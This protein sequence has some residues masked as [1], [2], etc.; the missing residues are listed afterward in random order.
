MDILKFAE[1]IG[2]LKRLKRTGWV[3]SNIPNPESVAEHSFRV[4]ILTMVLAPILGVDEAKAVKMAL[5]HDLGE[6][7][8]GDIVTVRRGKRLANQKTKLAAERK[9]LIHILT[10]IDS[11]Q[12]Y[13]SLF[14]EYEENKTPEARLVKQI[15][16][17]EMGI[18]ALEYEQDHGIDLE[19]F[20][21]TTQAAVIHEELRLILEV[22]LTR[23]NTKLK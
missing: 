2:K 23:R 11:P 3:R 1:T 19:E 21:E 9:A 20:F 13:I 7:E 10:L 5:I 12:A 8:I 18:Q 22:V 17:L 14:D 4:A 15:D 16:R 6:A